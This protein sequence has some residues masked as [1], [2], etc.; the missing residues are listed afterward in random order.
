MARQVVQVP[1]VSRTAWVILR[2]VWGLLLLSHAV[3]FVRSFASTQAS[4]GSRLALGLAIVFFAAK[5]LDVR[6]LRFVF[7]RRS[8]IA[9][10]MIVLLL[11]AG[12]LQRYTELDFEIPA[13]SLPLLAVTPFWLRRD[14]WLWIRG[15]LVRLA[16]GFALLTNGRGPAAYRRAFGPLQPVPQCIP[17]RLLAPRAPPV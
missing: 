11:H 9:A 3:W 2:G 17:C 10:A 6:A 7:S 13:W 5:L 16:H 12:A 4:F 15:I 1:G 8:L 14:P